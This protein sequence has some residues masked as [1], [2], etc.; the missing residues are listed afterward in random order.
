[1]STGN[2]DTPVVSGTDADALRAELLRR[3]LAGG[4]AAAPRRTG[5]PRAERSA[6]LP[7]SYGQQQM[8][9]LSRLEPDSPEYLVPL[10]LR[11]RGP[12][13]A[14]ALDRAWQGVVERH[15]ILRTRYVL[16]DDEPVQV[17]DAPGPLPLARSQAADDE[18]AQALVE[19]DLSR[20]FDLGRDWP[21]RGRLIR[22]S[23]DE[24]V[25]AVVFHHIAC[26]AWSTQVFGQ[27]LSELYNGA[28]PAPLAVQYA[29]YAAWQREQL[30]QDV[31]TRHIDNWKERLADLA[32]LDLPADRSRPAVRDG[33]G[34][35]VPFEVPEPLAAQLRELAAAQ[36]STLF[37][38][39]LAAYQTLLARYTGRTDIAVGTVV[40]GR[41]RPELQQLIGYGINTLVMRGD[42]SGDPAFTELLARTRA[43]VLDAYDHQELAFARVVEA[44][45]PERDLSRTPLFQVAFTLH[46]DRDAAFELPGIEVSPFEGSG[47]FAKFDLD[48]QLREGGDGSLGGHLEYATA[49]FDRTTVERFRG[50]LLRL[51]AGVAAAPGARL[52]VLEIIG[53]EE[54]AMLISPAEQPRPVTRRVHELFEEQATRTPNRVAVSFAGTALTYAELSARANRIAHALIAKGAG[55]ETLVGLSLER[56]IELMPALLGILKSGAAYLPLDPANP[57]DRIA[58]IVDDARASVVVTTR[59]HAG[60]FT[61][62]CCCST[63]TRNSSRPSRTPPRP[64]PAARRT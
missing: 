35:A 19:A 16:R 55:P 30:T 15:E 46:G 21:V 56:G 61:G 34:A 39:F 54:R 18:A 60:L 51:L 5:I 22:M 42:L 26:D 53:D 13:D 24:H 40:S 49:L 41:G 32:P 59:A 12:L 38:L 48:L 47:R 36:D 10:V 8:W 52:S 31:M 1:M 7:L 17:V 9:F 44:I 63:G 45:G 58:Y 25:L 37:M 50:H 43:T 23:A 62:S 33:A 11:L 28:A 2:M 29:D 3:R 4:R 64:S 6:S 27:E 57:A 14:D 20:T